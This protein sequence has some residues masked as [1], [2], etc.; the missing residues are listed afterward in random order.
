[1]K[2]KGTWAVV[3]LTLSVACSPVSENQQVSKLELSNRDSVVYGE[4]NRK[5]LFEVD[6]FLHQQSS[7]SVVALIRAPYL[8]MQSNDTYKLV[9]SNFG[10]AYRLCKSEP[11]RDQPIAADCSG[12]LVAPNVVL[13]A[14]HCVADF[15]DCSTMRFVFDYI[16]SLEG[17]VNTNFSK[18]QVFRC[19]RIIKKELTEAGQDYALIEL[20]R[21][22]L[23]REPLKL[24]RRNNIKPGQQLYT[25]GFPSG[26]PLKVADGAEVRDTSDLNYFQANLDTYQGNSGSPVFNADTGEVEGILVRGEEDFVTEGNCQKTKY[27]DE[28]GCRGEDVVYSHIIHKELKKYY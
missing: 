24:N 4:D 14:G 7:L 10:T 22:V 26:L 9:N 15:Y 21:E 16:V 17:V 18:D 25:I 13:T 12:S 5:D 6:S 11:F 23:D 1:M 3:L 2:L 20:D 8:V 27:C 19:K 28:D